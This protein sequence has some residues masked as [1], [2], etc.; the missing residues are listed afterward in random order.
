MSS[1][2]D[3]LQVLRGARIAPAIDAAA[4]GT[5]AERVA[6][7]RGLPSDRPHLDA[8]ESVA[9]QTGGRVVAPHVVCI[10]ERL[11]ISAMHGSGQLQRVCAALSSSLLPAPAERLIFL[12][13]ETTGLAGGT[14][15]VAFL[16][17]WIEVT[18]HAINLSQYIITAFAGEAAMLE[19]VVKA[20]DAAPTLVT[21]N[22]KSFDQP[23][24]TTRFR[25]HGI[26]HPVGRLHHADLLHPARR[27]FGRRWPNCRLQ[28]C[29]HRLLAVRRHNDIPGHEI[30]MVWFDLLRSG[31]TDALVQVISHNRVDLLSLAMLLPALD[32]VFCDPQAHAADVAAVARYW[33]ARDEP[34][35]AIEL[36]TC[37]PNLTD[38]ERIDLARWY[39]QVD[40]WNAAVE[41]WERG[42]VRHCCESLLNLAKFRE[43]RQQDYASAL[44]IVDRL[45][46]G[47]ANNEE[48]QRRYERL[49]RKIAVKEALVVEP[50]PE[51]DGPQAK[52]CE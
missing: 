1:I 48:Y 19:A 5:I 4:S 51:A 20:L 22:G 13:T 50:Q 47:D 11:P 27:A 46:H 44:L 35:R 40:D 29:E 18:A 33:H 49:K 31:T 32:A 30:P 7:L 36:M 26:D 15:T 24:L 14:G 3:K 2:R 6:H 17:G 28:T 52:N 25:L 9:V 42:A 38:A 10:E 43:H 45:L 39:R 12:D 16:V 8:A 21:F 23:L 37:Q 41:L 34:A